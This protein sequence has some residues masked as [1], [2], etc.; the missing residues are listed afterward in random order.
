MAVAA[1]ALAPVAVADPSADLQSKVDSSRG[2]GRCPPLQ[3]DPVLNDVAARASRET[4]AYITH[5]ARFVPLE[6]DPMPA[7]REVGYKTGKAKLL[8]GYGD[9]QV[10]GAGDSESKAIKSV[11]LEGWDSIPDCAYTKYG[12]NALSNDDGGYVVASVILA[13]A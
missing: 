2:P 5:N 8:L 13:G 9:P 3:S 11:L 4:D 6:N 7:L 12:V 10:G 1:V